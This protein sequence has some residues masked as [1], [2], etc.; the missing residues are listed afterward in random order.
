MK[1][2]PL[3][4]VLWALVDFQ[5]TPLTR[6]NLPVAV[7]PHLLN[8]GI[9]IVLLL[10]GQSMCYCVCVCVCAC[11]R[12]CVRACVCVRARVR[13]CVCACVCVCDV[14]FHYLHTQLATAD[15]EIKLLLGPFEVSLFGHSSYLNKLTSGR[16]VA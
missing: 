10:H 12:A 5:L 8:S 2:A 11:V 15:A 9:T 14:L 4:P 6:N 3:G 13:A 7:D 1:A 16:K